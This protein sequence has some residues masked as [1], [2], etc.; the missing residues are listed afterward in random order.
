ML[1]LRKLSRNR[2]TIVKVGDRP[3]IPISR[4]RITLYIQRPEK[5]ETAHTKKVSSRYPSVWASSPRTYFRKA[6]RYKRERTVGSLSPPQKLQSAERGR[7]SKRVT[8]RLTPWSNAVESWLKR[9]KPVDISFFRRSY[10][11]IPKRTKVY[12]SRSKKN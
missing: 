12:T 5:I 8:R 7:R 11:R 2:N 4:C 10:V 9:K 1:F 3:R 6:K